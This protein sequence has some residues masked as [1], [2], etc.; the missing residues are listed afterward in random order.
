M[1]SKGG[2]QDMEKLV[3]FSPSRKLLRNC[4]VRFGRT[5]GINA[6]GNDAGVL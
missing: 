5:W 1:N 3:Y 4:R 6:F 2:T